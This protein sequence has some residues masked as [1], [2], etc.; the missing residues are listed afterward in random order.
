MEVTVT[1]TGLTARQQ[2]WA[3]D[4]LDDINS[5]RLQDNLPAF[6]NLNEWAENE[7]IT[8]LRSMVKNKEELRANIRKEQWIVAT[9]EQRAAVDVALG[10]S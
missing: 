7:I 6:T 5:G 10:V 1:I 3:A 9:D 2:A 8:N 4:I